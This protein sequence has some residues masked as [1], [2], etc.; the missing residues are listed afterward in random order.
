MMFFWKNLK[1]KKIVFFY[2]IF[3]CYYCSMEFERQSKHSGLCPDTSSPVFFGFRNLSLIRNLLRGF[4]FLLD[5]TD[6][7]LNKCAQAQLRSRLT[8]WLLKSTFCLIFRFL[9]GSRNPSNVQSSVFLLQFPD[10]LW[11]L[12]GIRWKQATMMKSKP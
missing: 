4:S 6:F 12:L 8:N 10:H 2:L 9:L 3:S 11:N 5:F 7:T 1:L